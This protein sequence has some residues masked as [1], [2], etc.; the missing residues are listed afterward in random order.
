MKVKLIIL[1]LFFASFG[2]LAIAQEFAPPEEGKMISAI[3]ITPDFNAKAVLDLMQLRVGDGYRHAALQNSI[4]NIF[5]IGIFSDVRIS[6]AAQGENISLTVML[7]EIPKLEGISI[8]GNG[9]IS[10]QDIL[11]AAR[12]DNADR[13]D[14]SREQQII[15]GI[16]LAYRNQGYFKTEVNLYQM[17]NLETG[18]ERLEINIT[19]GEMTLLK[20][21]EFTGYPVF[22]I[23]EIM[24]NWQ[25]VAEGEKF[26]ED[27][28]VDLLPDLKEYYF[29]KGLLTCDLF[30]DSIIFDEPTNSIT[31]RIQVNAGPMVKVSLSPEGKDNRVLLELIPFADREISVVG[32]LELGSERINSTLQKSGFSNA[33][34]VV[35]FD[36]DPETA[37]LLVQVEIDR[38]TS[39]HVDKLI[40]EG[41][42]AGMVKQVLPL[43]SSNNHGWFSRAIYSIESIESDVERIKVFLAEQGYMRSEITTNMVAD[44]E[45]QEGVEVQILV[46]LKQATE[47]ANVSLVGNVSLDT[48]ELLAVIDLK[49]GEI[50]TR[51]K[52]NDALQR[53]RE[54][55]DKQGFV[56]AEISLTRRD[57]GN[58][59]ELLF[60]VNEKER[61][62]ITKVI[63]AGNQATDEQVILEA[64]T[65]TENDPFS[66]QAVADSQR[67]LNQLGIFD[68]VD[69]S[70]LQDE[71]TPWEKRVIVRVQEQKPYSILYGFGYN[72]EEQFRFS[73]GF[74]NSNLMGK[75]L[76]IGVG[77]RVSTLQQRYQVSFGS[78]RL[79][80]GL[81]RVTLRLFYEELTRLS[82]LVRR[83]GFVIESSGVNWRDWNLQGQMQYRWI[84]L[85][86]ISGLQEINRNEQA[87]RLGLLSLIANKDSRNDQL[88]PS[89]GSN[90]SIVLQL[91]P[92]VVGGDVKY[93][94][95]FFQHY[96]Y[97]PLT[98]K[99]VLAAGAR[100]GGAITMEQDQLLPISE[101]FFLGGSSSLRGFTLDT[102]GPVYTGADGEFY[103]LGGNA[104]FVGNIEARVAMTEGVTGVT[105]YDFGNVYSLVQDFSFADLNHTL[106]LGLRFA[107]PLG[108]LRVDYGWGLNN[109]NQEFY[110][111]F[112]HAF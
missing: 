79:L 23:A 7:E 108:P 13:Y 41:L 107:T 48:L 104:M 38:G 33:S 68:R 87:V 46:E 54:Y 57:R 5:S 11:E 37:D 8:L 34:S 47:V 18:G 22:P 35:A 21:V 39:F 26:V 77:T 90:T 72:S 20:K 44:P 49:L 3:K 109:N 63:V 25:G 58:D 24:A 14:A 17:T 101:R 106:G 83:K 84:D 27:V 60:D 66:N 64:L 29:G 94:R 85:D 75:G 9:P 32:I 96:S 51:E 1:L 15:N 93:L 103:P 71:T 78:S 67:A 59:L 99:L 56:E 111:T 89:G 19:T 6:W 42:D 50:A 52:L 16:T 61:S 110:F 30:L 36:L 70:T 62:V 74:S 86:R 43:L 40:L 28:F 45:D 80:W 73:F 65:F 95:T 105:F 100:F 53:L 92:P 4:R 97:L 102:V 82:Y 98:S 12:L 10:K 112:G 69:I 31:A 76:E 88:D 91:A 2:S 55:Y 81:S